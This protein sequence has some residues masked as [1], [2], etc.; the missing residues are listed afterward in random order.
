MQKHIV[1][2][3]APLIYIEPHSRKLSVL[4]SILVKQ[5]AL[6]VNG[7]NFWVAMK[8]NTEQ[9]GSIFDPQPNQT[10]GNIHCTTDTSEKVVGYIGAGNTVEKRV[11]I[12]NNLMPA[13]WNFPEDCLL[14]TV[15][16]NSDSLIYYFRDGGFSPIGET[17]SQ[18][19]EIRYM[20]SFVQ[21]VECTLNGTNIKPAFWP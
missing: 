11:F 15:P 1:L 21:C 17:R 7:Y 14:I 6:D 9:V 2:L 13:G 18:T 10:N 12:H 4:Y 16:A 3:Q 19:G 5:Y 8:S 20:S